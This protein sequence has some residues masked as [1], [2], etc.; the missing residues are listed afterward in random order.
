ML[1]SGAAFFV[2]VLFSLGLGFSG[3]TKPSNVKGFL[4]VFGEWNQALIFV[5]FGAVFTYA[6]FYRLILKRQRPLI[7]LKF[8]IPERKEIDKKLIFGST[9]F[10]LG[11]G[12]VGFCPAPAIVSLVSLSDSAFL[13]VGS[14]FLGMFVFSRLSKLTL[15]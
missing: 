6:I 1:Y 14:M 9:L 13:F 3:M 10:G 2:G 15:R 12:I 4:D 11:W 8:L 5:M 7:G